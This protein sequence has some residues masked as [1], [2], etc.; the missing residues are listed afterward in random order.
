MAAQKVNVR[1]SLER[2]LFPALEANGFVRHRP[3]EHD[4][5]L[6][7]GPFV[8]RSARGLDVFE[9]QFDKNNPARFRVNL[10]VLRPEWKPDDPWV[11]VD[12]RRYCL[13]RWGLPLRLW[14]GVR[15]KASAGIT[16][17]EYD[18]AAELLIRCLPQAERL[19]ASGKRSWRMAEYPQPLWVGWLLI[20]FWTMVAAC[21]V[22]TPFLLLRGIVIL[23][24][25]LLSG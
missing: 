25:R 23:V 21:V 24:R 20:L 15:K 9:I 7:F 4:N 11:S 10:A 1:R 12:G 16:E 6:P 17:E 19:F 8:R 3:A 14:F 5:L 18:A 22:L 13:M 2:L